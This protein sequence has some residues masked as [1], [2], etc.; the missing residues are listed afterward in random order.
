MIA[1]VSQGKLVGVALNKNPHDSKGRE[2]INRERGKRST[3][4]SYVVCISFN[5]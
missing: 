1:S 5:L 3:D 2:R 4:L